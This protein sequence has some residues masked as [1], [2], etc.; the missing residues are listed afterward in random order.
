M[1]AIAAAAT[2]SMNPLMGAGIIGATA[3]AGAGAPMAYDYFSGAYGGSEAQ[4][5]LET[6]NSARISE[7]RDFLIDSRLS[8]ARMGQDFQGQQGQARKFNDDLVKLDLKQQNRQKRIDEL[9]PA[10][11]RADARDLGSSGNIFDRMTSGFSNTMASMARGYGTWQNAARGLIPGQEG[12]GMASARTFAEWEEERRAKLE[13]QNLQKEAEKDPN[14]T[15]IQIA[16]REARQAETRAK[17]SYDLGRAS[18]RTSGREFNDMFARQVKGELIDPQEIYEAKKRALDRR[19]DILQR[20]TD[21]FKR[22]DGMRQ[23]QEQR[24]ALDL[25]LPRQQ[26]QFEQDRMN[27][28]FGFAGRRAG[29]MHDP[30]ERLN[31]ESDLA[32]NRIR[33][34][35]GLNK[36]QQDDLV[37]GVL[38]QQ[39]RQRAGL[40]IDRDRFKNQFILDP[41]KRTNAEY[42][43]HKR[44]IQENAF[45]KGL[46]AQEQEALLGNFEKQRK[47]ALEQAG[48]YPGLQGDIAEG[49]IDDIRLR[50]KMFNRDGGGM[51]SKFDEAQSKEWKEMQDILR[52]IEEELKKNRPKAA[53]V[54]KK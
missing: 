30:F 52:R 43:A 1:T 46:P 44:E 41:I 36:A 50:Q 2:G 11:M 12:Y 35:N 7:S 25:D 29:L 53:V 13:I 22:E 6:S 48:G 45:F 33:A 8:T 32:I 37:Q 34:D 18:D 10:A 49:S 14:R 21:P 27:K 39:D 42:D 24:E 20:E 28:G 4:E 3:I 23:I 40:E 17:E 16:L 54:K 47:A 19:E 38:G 26:A 9:T 5:K 51:N 31:A 15:D